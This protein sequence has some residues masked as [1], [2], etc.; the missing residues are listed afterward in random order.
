M[1]THNVV[2][3]VLLVVSVLVLP[4]CGGGSAKDEASAKAYFGALSS[5]DPEIMQEADGAAAKGSAA[6]NFA[7]Y[8]RLVTE[9]DNQMG[10][11][12][13]DGY[14]EEIKG[15]F[16]LC[17]AEDACR[18]ITDI[19]YLKGKIST[20]SVRGEPLGDSIRTYRDHEV[21]MEGYGVAELL[22]IAQRPKGGFDAFWSFVPAADDADMWMLVVT[23][24]GEEIGLSEYS[25]AGERQAGEAYI[26]HY[27]FEDLN[28]DQV[29]KIALVPS[30]DE[31]A[32]QSWW[33]TVD[34]D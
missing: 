20:F 27:E 24:D 15:G 3:L 19:Q 29:E 12:Y 16:K 18:E 13:E 6:L 34:W 31:P 2:S 23:K 8:L 14:Y 33:T 17:H 7:T 9:G 32:S 22:L 26:Y 5:F 21:N 28:M 25:R 1:K 10:Y 4:G 11:T 30:L